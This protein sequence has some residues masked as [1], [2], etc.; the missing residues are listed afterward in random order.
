MRAALLVRAVAL[1]FETEAETAG[2]VSGVRSMLA[3]F[4]TAR[5]CCWCNAAE[6]EAE[7]AVVTGKRCTSESLVDDDLRITPPLPLPP[8]ETVDIDADT[9]ILLRV[10]PPPAPA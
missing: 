8:P 7:D 5:I 10:L 4:G 2:M 1:L 6:D 9:S 3:S